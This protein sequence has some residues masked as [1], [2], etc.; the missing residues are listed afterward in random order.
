MANTDTT[1][2]GHRADTAWRFAE[3]I[4]VDGDELLAAAMAV[5]SNL[6]PQSVTFNHA[7]SVAGVA[8]KAA[9][10]ARSASR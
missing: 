4:G 10:E 1:P 5:W 8:L 2:T 7:L 9:M 6:G 3:Q